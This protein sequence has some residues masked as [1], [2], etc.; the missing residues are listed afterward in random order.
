M[1]LEDRVA[2]LE[3]R[4]AIM[5]LMAR[6]S[7]GVAA[8]DREQILACFTGDGTMDVGPVRVS[9]IDQMR[10]FLSD[11]KPGNAHLEG[12]DQASTSTPTISNVEIHLDGDRATATSMCVVF[13][14]GGRDGGPIV[15]VR[16]TEYADDL[17]CVDGTWLFATRR[18]RTNW[19]YWV[20]GVVPT[21]PPR[22][23]RSE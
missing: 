20:P 21:A 16:G 14:A 2:A 19:E 13:H 4:T 7:R 11:M 1:S 3:A 12:F 9:G 15:M 5:E 10:E 18:H 22:W 23:P 8:R 17:E 6:Y